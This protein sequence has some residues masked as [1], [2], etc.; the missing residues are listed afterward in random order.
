MAQV[1]VA[2]ADDGM[3]DLL[4]ELLAEAGH[5]VVG[6]ADGEVAWHLLRTFPASM[7]AVLDLVTPRLDG[8]HVLQDILTDPGITRQHGL[9][10]LTTL[11]L[12]RLKLSTSNVFSDLPESVVVLNKPFD[13]EDLEQAVENVA[14]KCM[15]GVLR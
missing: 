2:N 1:L 11:P 15:A 13:L 6:V 4:V 12:C 7:V 5:E 10:V 3:R 14:Q 8:L 9:V